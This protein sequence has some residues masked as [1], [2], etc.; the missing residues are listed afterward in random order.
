ML[1]HSMLR[2]SRRNPKRIVV[3]LAV[4]AMACFCVEPG[5]GAQKEPPDIFPSS[6]LPANAQP[7]KDAPSIPGQPVTIPDGTQV[8]LRLAQPV[9]GMTRSIRG[10]RVYSKP[11]DKVRLVAADDVRVNGLV[12]ISKGGVGQA[13]VIKAD[14]PPINTYSYNDRYAALADIFVPKTGTVSLQLDW[15]EDITGRAIPLRAYP[16][17][18]AKPFTMVVLAENGGI[19]A[20]PPELSQDLKF[21]NLSHAKQWA[22]VGTRLIGFVHCA[23]NVDPAELKDAQALLPIP[24]PTAMLTIFRTKG[25]RELQPQISCDGKE[26]PTVGEREYITLELVPGET[27]LRH[28]RP[29]GRGVQRRVRGGLLSARAVP[30]ISQRVGIDD[31]DCGRRG[32][33]RIEPAA[34]GEHVRETAVDQ[35]EP[36]LGCG[37]VGIFL[38]F[39]A[40]TDR[41]QPG[42]L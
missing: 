9:R 6:A 36:S 5:A 34:V 42:Q 14:P 38:L 1:D 40:G 16:A 35:C 15:V 7:A 39:L 29:T 4:S 32:R 28:H 3:C 23:V 8:Q 41:L 17:G 20:R 12:V 37:R 21:K 2:F 22:P 30:D 13:T 27:F 19:V 10:S 11:G 18:E 24:N 31:A 26:I 25:H 33:Q